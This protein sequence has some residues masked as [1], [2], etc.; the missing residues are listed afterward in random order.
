[1]RTQVREWCTCMQ[2]QC[3]SV[4]ATFNAGINFLTWVVA[5]RAK[6][7]NLLKFHL[8]PNYQE[9]TPPSVE[10]CHESLRAHVKILAYLRSATNTAVSNMDRS[11]TNLYCFLVKD[12][13]SCSKH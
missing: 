4:S 6:I 9:E 11:N 5:F 3:S 7:A 10:L 12:K 1:M 13:T 2:G 8:P